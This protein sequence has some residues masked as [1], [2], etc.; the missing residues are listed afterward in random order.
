MRFV[1]A[2]PQCVVIDPTQLPEICATA[3]ID[4]QARRDNLNKFQLEYS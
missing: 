1:R 3:L 4:S 2:N